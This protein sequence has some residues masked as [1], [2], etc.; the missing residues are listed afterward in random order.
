MHRRSR[1]VRFL[2][3]LENLIEIHEHNSFHIFPSYG[4]LYSRS[5]DKSVKLTSE[6]PKHIS[7]K[8]RVLEQLVQWCMICVGTSKRTS[9][10]LYRVD[11]AYTLSRFIVSAKTHRFF[12]FFFF[13]FQMKMLYWNRKSNVR[14]NK[15]IDL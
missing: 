12:R 11:I 9:N 13:C 6:I 7:T 4:D 14:G 15:D 1:H 8:A 3:C 5:R 2:F 10:K